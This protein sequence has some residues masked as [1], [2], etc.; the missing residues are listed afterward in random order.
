MLAVVVSVVNAQAQPKPVPPAKRLQHA[1]RNDDGV[2]TPREMNK[3]KQWEHKQLSTVN[4]PWEKRADANGDGKVEPAEA[5]IYRLQVVD[6]N[7]DGT[8]TVEERR[9]YYASWKRVVN[10]EAEKKYDASGDGYLEWPEARAFLK[11][12]L[13]VINTDGKAIVNPDIEREFDDNG[14]GVI[15]RSEAVQLKEA[16]E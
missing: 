1:D 10:T 12:R 2:V 5:R 11:D 3:E 15:D 6:V 9:A 7:K 8:I 4:Q 16:L 14:D 13:T